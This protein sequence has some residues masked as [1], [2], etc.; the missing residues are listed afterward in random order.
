MDSEDLEVYIYLD[1]VGQGM[2]LTDSLGQITYV[3]RE[4]G[5]YTFKYYWKHTMSSVIDMSE[6][7]SETIDLEIDSH[8]IEP[9]VYFV[10]IYL[11]MKSIKTCK[12]CLICIGD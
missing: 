8:A 5:N 7:V 3:S 4:A 11:S 6:S 9:V 10:P 12:K 2:V 1:G